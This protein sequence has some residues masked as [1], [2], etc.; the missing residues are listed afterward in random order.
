MADDKFLMREDLT[1]YMGQAALGVGRMFIVEN[2]KD[3]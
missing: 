2:P 1:D 3:W